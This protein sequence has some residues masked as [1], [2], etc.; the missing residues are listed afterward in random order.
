[1]SYEPRGM[2]TK[3]IYNTIREANK[4]VSIKEIVEKT[5]IN[6]NTVRG[7]VQRLSKQ[8]LIRRLSKGIYEIVGN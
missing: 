5:G 7:V 3:R 2:K 1:M 6:Y 8:G 4:P